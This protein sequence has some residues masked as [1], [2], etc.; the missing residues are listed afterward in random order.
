MTSWQSSRHLRG[1]RCTGEPIAIAAE[2]QPKLLVV[3]PQVAV[4][5]ACHR[6]GYHVHHLLRHHADIGLPTAEIAEAI[7]AKA[8]GEMAEQDDVMLQRNVGTPPTAAAPAT[9]TTSSSSA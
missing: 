2:C 7:I 3:D 4:A 9:T 6:I 1:D 5:S 8:V